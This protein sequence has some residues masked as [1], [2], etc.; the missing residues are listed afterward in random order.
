MKHM[1][2][3]SFVLD[4]EAFAVAINETGRSLQL[5][6]LTLVNGSET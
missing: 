2:A 5:A 1:F 4:T 3:S 6:Q